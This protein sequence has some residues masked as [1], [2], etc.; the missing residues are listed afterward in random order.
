MSERLGFQSRFVQA[1]VGHDIADQLDKLLHE[2]L[3]EPIQK[4]ADE[5]DGIADFEEI[6]PEGQRTKPVPPAP[7]EASARDPIIDLD[8]PTS[9]D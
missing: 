4:L 3:P 9:G 6:G 8:T 5:V 1:K 2:P 7:D